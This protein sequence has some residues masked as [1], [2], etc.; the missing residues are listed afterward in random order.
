MSSAVTACAEADGC[1]LFHCTTGKDRTGILACCL[2]GAVGV[3][4]EDIAADYC[5]SQVY[6]QDMFAGMRDGTLTI[7]PGK[8]HFEPYV[9]QTPFEAMVK[10]YD[11]FTEEFDWAQP[12]NE[13]TQLYAKWVSDGTLTN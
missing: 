9:F 1:V 7:R 4:R 5:L 8:T 6:L 10:F 11:F 12:I 13:N 3:S 2:L